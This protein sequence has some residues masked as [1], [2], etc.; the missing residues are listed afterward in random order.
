MA[1]QYASNEAALG[2]LPPLKL[3]ALPL[4]T[5]IWAYIGRDWRLGRANRVGRTV[6][7]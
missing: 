7:V 5:T 4:F 2:T 1:T 6:W 3:V